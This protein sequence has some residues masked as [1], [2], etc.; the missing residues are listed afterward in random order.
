MNI[1]EF[2]AKESEEI[3]G[4][5]N[6]TVSILTHYNFDK[7]VKFLK[8]FDFYSIHNENYRTISYV[9]HDF[10]LLEIDFYYQS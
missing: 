3:T 7:D 8:I 6:V 2:S 9:C 4:T 10:C 5:A 1:E